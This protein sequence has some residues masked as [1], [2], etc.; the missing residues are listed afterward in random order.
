MLRMLQEDT[1]YQAEEAE[2]RVDNIQNAESLYIYNYIHVMYNIY[3]AY[4]VYNV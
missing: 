1:G 3:N 2:F 4:S